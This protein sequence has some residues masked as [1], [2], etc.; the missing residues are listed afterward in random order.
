MRARGELRSDWQAAEAMSRE[1]IERLAEE[2][3]GPL[4]AGWEST[5]EIGIPPRK[6]PVHI[7]LDADVLAWFRA[8]GPGYQTRINAVLRAFV[9]ARQLAEPKSR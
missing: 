2:D 6:E 1:E 4:P 7:R 3:D 5:V 8:H 9:Q